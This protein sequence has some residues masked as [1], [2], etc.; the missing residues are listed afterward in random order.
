MTNVTALC[1]DGRSVDVEL[2]LTHWD[3]PSTGEVAGFAA[4]MRDAGERLRLQAERDAYQKKLEDQLSAIEATS[5]GVG[6]TDAE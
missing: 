2:S 6:I 1:R 3:D 5:D 4:I